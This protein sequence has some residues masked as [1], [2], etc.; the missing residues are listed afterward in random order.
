M[1]TFYPTGGGS[2]VELDA[3][4]AVAGDI[5]KGKVSVDK[6]GEPITG[7]LEL[8]GDATEAYVYIGKTFYSTDPKTQKR[9]P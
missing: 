3:I 4:T 5:V 2:N 8:S 1:A 6:E 7:A 9:E